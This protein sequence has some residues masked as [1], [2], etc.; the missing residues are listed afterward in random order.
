M[1]SCPKPSCSV[2]DAASEVVSKR[3]QSATENN[4]SNSMKPAVILDLTK[5]EN[6]KQELEKEIKR[7]K[8]YMIQFELQTRI[9][10]EILDDSQT[11]E[12]LQPPNVDD[13]NL[14]DAFSESGKNLEPLSLDEDDPVVLYDDDT[15]LD[16]GPPKLA[17]VGG[18]FFLLFS[19]L[20]SSSTYHNVFLL[21]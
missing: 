18:T 6:P 5:P 7:R 9:K 20:D 1:K 19:Y 4:T 12:L 16:N 21:L 2:V 8:A 10:Q 13:S 3:P 17:S 14:A 15:D 11:S